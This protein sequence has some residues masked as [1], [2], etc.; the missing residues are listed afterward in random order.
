MRG[1]RN[2]RPS[3]VLSRERP[4]GL[5]AANKVKFGYHSPFLPTQFKVVYAAIPFMK[6]AVMPDQAP[7]VRSVSAPDGALLEYEIVGDGPPLV[8]LRGILAGRVSFSR[9]A[10][11]TTV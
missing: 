1:Q 4:F 2:V 9:Q 11:S 8:M 5:A 3:G 10:R 6:E 7:E